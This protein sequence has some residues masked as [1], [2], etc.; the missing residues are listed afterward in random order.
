MTSKPIIYSDQ[1][2]SS[3]FMLKWLE[4]IE[5]QFAM[6]LPEYRAYIERKMKEETAR[7]SIKNKP[8]NCD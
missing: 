1:L 4:E 3:Y 6:S 8:G 5:K 2:F 7:R